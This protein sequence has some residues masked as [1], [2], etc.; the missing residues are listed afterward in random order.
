MPRA[1]RKFYPLILWILK[2]EDRLDRN[3]SH[4][5]KSLSPKVDNFSKL[6]TTWEDTYTQTRELAQ[7]WRDNRDANSSPP[8]FDY[9]SIGANDGTFT[10]FSASFELILLI[11]SVASILTIYYIPLR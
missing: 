9:S 10:F 11:K 8:C 3:F 6:E 5:D 7:Q 1:D 2:F 4:P